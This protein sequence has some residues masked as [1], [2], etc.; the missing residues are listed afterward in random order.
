VEYWDELEYWDEVESGVGGTGEFPRTGDERHTGANLLLR[1]RHPLE[2]DCFGLKQSR[3]KG[4][5]L[6]A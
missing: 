4:V 3:S 1:M 6:N 2:H 5:C